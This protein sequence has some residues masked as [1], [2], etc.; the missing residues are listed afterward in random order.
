VVDLL[1]RPC[2][3]AARRDVEHASEG[4]GIPWVLQQPEIGEDVLDLPALVEA[5]A[6]DDQVGE[7]ETEEGLFEEPALCVHPE[8]DR[9]AALRPPG[10]DALDDPGRLLELVPGAVEPDGLPTRA[11][12]PQRLALAPK[13][14][15]DEG[16][17]D[18]EDGLARAI[19]LLEAE[20]PCP[21]EVVLEVE[22]VVDLR[23]PPG[24]DRLVL[25]P[26][27]REVAAGS[28]ELS[29]KLV[30][31]AVGVLVLVDEDEGEAGPPRLPDPRLALE[32]LHGAEQEVVEVERPCRLQDPPVTLF[33]P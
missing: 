25:V 22:D 23:A 21:R 29:H 28:G 10:D 12:R 4:D 33:D 31:G 18:V 24:V 27:H 17:G 6:S 11:H 7:T 15:L 19:V 30:L 3:D 32:Q 1:P 14:S 5:R 9:G 26:H 2:S 16:R 8:Q 20:D 13:V